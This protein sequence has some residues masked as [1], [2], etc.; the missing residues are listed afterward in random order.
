MHAP[1]RQL[2]LER[3]RLDDALRP[4]LLAFL[5]VLDLDETAVADSLGQGR[6]EVG[7]CF[8]DLR[9][10]CLRELELAERLFELHAHPVE[11]CVRVG[12]DHRPDELECKHDRAGFERG[13][14]RC[15][16]ERVAVELLVDVDGVALER[17]VHRV[18][19]AA[20]VDEVEQLQVFLELLGG[21]V[22]SLDDLAGPG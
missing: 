3:V 19:A 15:E 9:V 4:G 11:R 12:R 2:A 5:L 17:R 7:L 18:A 22:E 6:D 8:G 16:A 21:D 14:A 1:V 20:E 10:R 13:Q